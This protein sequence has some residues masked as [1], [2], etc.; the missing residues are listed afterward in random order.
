MEEKG[1]DSKNLTSEQEVE[2]YQHYVE[3]MKNITSMDNPPESRRQG[4]VGDDD[5]QIITR[6][7]GYMDGKNQEETSTGN[8]AREP[9][10]SNDEMQSFYDKQTEEL[11][12]LREKMN[13]IKPGSGD[14]AFGK[15]MAKR[16]HL[17]MKI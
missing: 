3:E 13:K 17:D 8:P 15:R 4:G 5:I 1:Y 9:V 6:T 14:K 11:N 12:S 16:L 7:Y 10:F 2:I